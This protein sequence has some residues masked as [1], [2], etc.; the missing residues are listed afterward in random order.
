MI[1]YTV[2]A[3]GKEIMANVDSKKISEVLGISYINVQK[4]ALSGSKINLEI[5]FDR[6]DVDTEMTLD[7]RFKNYYG[8]DNY[9]Q[10][11]Q[12]NRRYGK[13]VTV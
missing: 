7:D 6:K 1:R 12:M 9:R 13:R 3:N 10:W 8:I 2:Y 5:S 11:V 4:A